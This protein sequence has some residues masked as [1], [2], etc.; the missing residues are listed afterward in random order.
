M[1]ITANTVGVVTEEPLGDEEAVAVDAFLAAYSGN[2]GTSY[3]TDL[4]IFAAWSRTGGLGLFEL[5][6]PHLELFG[7][8]WR[9]T[10]LVGARS[11]VVRPHARAG[12]RSCG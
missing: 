11:K 10:E 7:R 9:R 6:R 4:R 8:G 1:S 5:H 3:A 12:A 2:T